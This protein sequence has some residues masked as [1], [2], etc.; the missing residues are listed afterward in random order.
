MIIKK[1]NKKFYS[2]NYIL[3][4]KAFLLGVILAEF[5]LFIKIIGERF[6]DISISENKEIWLSLIGIFYFLIVI[7]CSFK[8]VL[9]RV[10]GLIKSFRSDL[11]KLRKRTLTIFR[12]YRIELLFPFSLGIVIA[13]SFDFFGLASI[14]KWL[15]LLTWWQMFFII[16]LPIIFLISIA[17]R[18][19]FLRYSKIE[20]Q[21]SSFMSDK[22]GKNKEDDQF[23]FN[24]KAENFADSVYNNGSPESLVFGIDAPWGTGKSTFVNLCKEYWKEKYSNHIIVYNF[25]PLRYENKDNL[26][27]IFVDGLIKEIKKHIFVPEIASLVSRY[28]KILRNS[29]PSL[30]LKGL[31][32]DLL[33]GNESID[34]I[35]KRLE[36]ALSNIDKKIIII[37]DDLDRLDF[38]EIQ[39]VL[40]VVKKSFMLPNISYVLCYDTENIAALEQRNVNTEKISEFLEKFINIKISLYLDRKLLL[41][42]F[43][44]NKDTAL[45]DN[46]L[47]NTKLVS[48]AAEGLKDIFESKD[49]H[50]YISFIG[51]ARKL[52]RLINTIVLL[53]VYETD[54]QNYDFDKGD[55]IHL[56]LIYINYP[57]IF[58]KIYNTETQGKK[59]FFSVV[60]NHSK[61]SIP[62]HNYE[63]SV[64]YKKYIEDLSENQK[65]LINKVF[66]VDQRLIDSLGKPLNN[67]EKITRE[68][69]TSYA[70]FN[71][72]IF[73]DRDR[74]LERYLNLIVNKSN[75][76]KAEQY[77]FYIN[78]KN[79]ILSGKAINDVLNDNKEFSH[80][81]S[82]YSHKMLWD[83]LD[84]APQEEFTPENSREII[85]Y[86]INNLHRYSLLII[87]EIGI[88][89]RK[90]LL[91]FIVKL[92]D[93]VGWNDA[94]GKFLYSDNENISGIADWIFGE[95][96]HE[97]EGV[98]YTLSKEKRGVMGLYDLLYFRSNCCTDIGIDLFNLSRSLSLHGNP[99]VPNSGDI[100]SILIEEMREISQKIFCIFKS[101][102]IDKERNIFDEIDKLSIEDVCGDY[103][104]FVKSKGKSG[105]ITDLDNR[106]LILKNSMKIFIT[107]QLG[108]TNTNN[109]LGCGYYDTSGREDKQGIRKTVND[110][111][112]GYCF[113]PEIS[114]NCIHFIDYLLSNLSRTHAFY[115]KTNRILNINEF[116]IS[117]DKEELIKYWNTQGDIIKSKVSKSEDRKVYTSSYTASYAKDVE[118]IYNVL[119][120]LLSSNNEDS[121]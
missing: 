106:L 114:K 113:N 26:L 118:G 56:L 62:E 96:K 117:L 84:K 58:R 41:E 25:E 93:K 76:I 77:R 34:D 89:F 43:T 20:V 46:P 72:S 87:D 38:S 65:F 75:P 29:K 91:I 44:D 69:I 73:N 74:N 81:E 78:L 24:D 108:S 12:I 16:L 28:T 35:F 88:G 47:A 120:N 13:Y 9:K 67:K 23:K 79:D 52:K 92:L 27:R 97:N 64:D 95:G 55:L 119:D 48:K 83:V 50:L 7:Y 121:I 102:Y 54:F 68:M 63:N 17:L 31:R 19:L 110:Y 82:E 111:F 112:F 115:G 98:I 107:Y 90:T 105:E 51:D 10:W 70:C 40:Q 15:S 1:E 60:Y 57:N 49:F 80:I 6:V 100:N 66:N 109:G 36:K 39:E 3:F 14:K 33:I 4:T 103:S 5:G 61:G 94:Q 21:A 11:K 30:S 37:V 8:K 32:F 116:F 71:G 42:Y 53:G 85:N 101:C 99:Q 104:E 86:A 45:A 2:V 18:D 59:G 22:E